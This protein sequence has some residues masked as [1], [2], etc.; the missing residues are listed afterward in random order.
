MFTTNTVPMDVMR[1]VIGAVPPLRMVIVRAA[2][3]VLM[4]CPAKSRVV[5][6]ISN[7]GEGA[8]TLDAL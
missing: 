8:A 2:L 4:T 1:T 7:C 3:V 6:L 5:A